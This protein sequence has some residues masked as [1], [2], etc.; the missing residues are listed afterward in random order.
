MKWKVF[1]L[2]I[3]LAGLYSQSFAQQI[4]DPKIKTVGF[5]PYRKHITTIN[6]LAIGLT[7]DPWGEASDSI[8]TKVN[9]LNIELGPFGIIGGIWGTMFG[10][11]GVKGNDG[12]RDSFFSNYNDT[13]APEIIPENI[14]R[15][16]G[17]SI[18]VGGVS[19]TFNRGI[20]INGLSSFCHQT[21]GIQVTGLI[22]HT[23]QCNGITIA[24]LANVT[25]RMNGV[26]IGLINKCKTGN[27]VQIG[28]FNRIG[29]RVIPFIN[30]RFH[31]D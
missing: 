17:L 5:T 12:H 23:N 27:L 19:E 24:G 31:K 20:I 18:S 13:E 4:T 16:N 9:G 25:N 21:N 15:L 29:K 14:T 1:I 7:A 26:Q 22:N 3:F 10:L 2:F 28:L 8:Y 11:V 30:M 6:G